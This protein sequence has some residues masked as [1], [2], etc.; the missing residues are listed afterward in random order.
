MGVKATLKPIVNKY[1]WIHLSLGLIGNIMFLCGSLLFL[2][3]L[4]EYK[5]T[6]IALF[7]GGSFLMLIGSTGRLLVDLWSVKVPRQQQNNQGGYKQ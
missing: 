6:R 7:I 1:G 2:P 4:E 5:S 3:M